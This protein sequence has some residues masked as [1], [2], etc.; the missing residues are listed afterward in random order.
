MFSIDKIQKVPPPSGR[1]PHNVCPSAA[2][3][4]RSGPGAALLWLPAADCGSI[5][6]EKTPKCSPAIERSED[7][8]VTPGAG[9]V[10]SVI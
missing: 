6:K 8:T 4:E 3:C 7:P 9:Y 1:L 2:L 10:S 5:A